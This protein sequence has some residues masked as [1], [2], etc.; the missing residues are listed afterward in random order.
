MIRYN[1]RA[2]MLEINA[3]DQSY[4]IEKGPITNEIA[5]LTRVWFGDR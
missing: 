4:Y 3:H 2:V 1:R 5:S